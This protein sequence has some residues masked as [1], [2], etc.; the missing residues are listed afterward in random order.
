MNYK[1]V[2]YIRYADDFIIGVIGSKTDA[3]KIKSDIKKFLA[4][5]LKLRMSEQKT[6]ITHTSDKARFLGYDITV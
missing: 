5:K 4:E 6:K 3:E 1:S 2:K